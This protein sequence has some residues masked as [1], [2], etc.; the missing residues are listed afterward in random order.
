MTNQ[1]LI[2]QELINMEN[3]F[4]VVQTSD[5][6]NK[7][8]FAK[9]FIP[10]NTKIIEY[11]GE[12]ISSEEGDKRSDKQIELAKSNPELGSVYIF[13][14]DEDYDL[15][16]NFEYNT[17]RLIN[18]SC[19]PNCKFEIEDGHI[20]IVSLKDVKEGEEITYNYG[21]DF[22]EDYKDHLCKCMSSNCIGY[23]LAEEHL[24]KLKEVEA[25]Q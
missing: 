2:N 6:H 8:V 21:Y 14:L 19:S 5:I 1:T 22:D 16:G 24:S 15:D 10:K 3:E 13:E 25:K 17:A 11:V 20:W 12:R 4:I 18:H 7:G 9:T 23:I